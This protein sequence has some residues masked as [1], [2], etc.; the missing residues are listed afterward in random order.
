MSG[1]DAPALRLILLFVVNLYILVG[2]VP[3]S[4]FVVHR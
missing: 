4:L 3:G 2:H 1:F